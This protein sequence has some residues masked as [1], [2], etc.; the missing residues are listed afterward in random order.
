M[1]LKIKIIPWF[2]RENGIEVFLEVG[3]GVYLNIVKF[4]PQEGG[5]TYGQRSKATQRLVSKEVTSFVNCIKAHSTCQPQC[6][7]KYIESDND[8]KSPRDK[9]SHT[10]QVNEQQR[11]SWLHSFRLLG[12]LPLFR[13]PEI[14][15]TRCW[16]AFLFW[17]RYGLYFLGK[18]VLECRKTVSIS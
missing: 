8:V 16:K 11:E 6:D 18:T 9:T 10:S 13:Q 12:S 4:T 17:W 15:T 7:C 2:Y 3:G 14:R 5:E 1:S